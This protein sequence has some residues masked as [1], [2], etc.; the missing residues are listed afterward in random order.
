MPDRLITA[1]PHG[2]GLV[3]SAAVTTA[4]V[5]EIRAR[6]D[7]AP[8]TAAAVG[9]LATGAA[10]LAASL[11]PTE[12]LSLH[13]VGDGPLESLG[14]DAWYLDAGRIGVRAYAR[15]PHVDLP[16]SARGKLDVGGAIGRGSLRVTRARP[17]G[18]P[19]VGVVPLRN[20]EIAEDI[21][22]YLA[23]SEQIPS[24]V[25]LGVLADP[26]GI[27]AA[28]GV[29]VQVLPGTD[30]AQIAALEARAGRLPPVTGTIARGAGADDLLAALIG[31]IAPGALRSIELSFACLCS[32][33]KV[34]VT[35][36]S[37]GRAELERMAHER[38]ATDVVCE[39]CKRCFAFSRAEIRALAA[40]G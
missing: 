23:D 31:D 21:A 38:D 33:A 1:A 14:A 30:E 36:R 29:A 9:R 22:G 25:A 18:A 8:T 4:L 40:A 20:G 39:F 27:A 13:V 15:H 10:L 32:R 17:D 12:R 19:Y 16:P 6:H 26:S 24:V 34:E 35:L 5:A 11:G 28:G 7:L 37:F 3:G 2:R